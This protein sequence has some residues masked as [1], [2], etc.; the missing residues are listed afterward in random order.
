[1]T[2]WSEFQ[3][4]APDLAAAVQHRFDAHRHKVLATV[5]RDGAPRISGIEGTFRDGELWPRGIP[6]ALKCPDLL[7]DPRFALHSATVDAPEDG[8]PTLWSGDAKIAGRAVEVTDPA[9]FAA[10][11]DATPQKPPGPFHLF[12]VSV[13]EA[14]VV[15]V[16]PGADHLLIESWHEGRGTSRTERR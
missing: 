4:E 7:L 3:A 16:G 10:F 11:A 5:R 14:V 13:S 12:V 9:V 8:D 2:S 15:R 6:G 1:M